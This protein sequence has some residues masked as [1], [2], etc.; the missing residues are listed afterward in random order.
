ML[1]PVRPM[2]L[3]IRRVVPAFPVRGHPEHA[4]SSALGFIQT[5]GGGP[6][7]FGHVSDVERSGIGEIVEGR[8]ISFDME[9][10][11]PDGVPPA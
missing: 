8:K 4:F 9:R 2:W 10:D 5:D 11:K 1:P 6:D 7:A 3:S